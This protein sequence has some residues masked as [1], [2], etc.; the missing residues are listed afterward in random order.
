[1]R[2]YEKAKFFIKSPYAFKDVGN[3]EFGI[4]PNANEIVYEV[5]LFDFERVKEIYEMNYNEKIDK[6]KDL[7]ERGLKC[8]RACEYQKAID[9][10]ERILKYVAAN[11]E[12]TDYV[13]GLPFKIAANLNA[14]LCYLKTKDFLKAKVKSEKVVK[15]DPDN[16]KG[17]FRLGEAFIGLKE[18]KNAVKAYENASKLEPENSAAK[19]QLITARK[20]LKKQTEDEK[21]LYSSIFAR[22]S[23][24]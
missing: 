20:L 14:A 17:Y 12:D 8:V 10:Y 18:Y 3:T 5:V 2:R 16:V 19:K 13:I 11:K 22:M 4:P 21:R 9:Y 6:S 24:E 7:K 15:L 1:M 23:T